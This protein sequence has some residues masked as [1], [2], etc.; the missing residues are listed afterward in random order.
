MSRFRFVFTALIGLLVSPGISPAQQ[1]F[2]F[3]GT[4]VVGP[5]KGFSLAKFDEETGVLSPPSF[6]L[7]AEAPAFF[8]LDSAGKHL[9]TVNSTAPEFQSTGEGGM[10]SYSIDPKTG[11]LTLL[12]T[13]STNGGDPSYI[14]LDHTEH[15]ALVA[16]YKGG[17]VIVYR[18][19]P[20]GSFGDQTAFDQHT[21]KGTDPTRQSKPFAHSIRVDPTN[22]FAICCDLGLDKVF[23]YK[24]DQNTGSLSP[25][26]PPFATVKAGSG[27]RH[28]CFSPD[29]KFLY[30]DSE[31]GSIVTVFAW[32]SDAGKLTVVQEISTLPPGFTGVSTDAEVLVHP[33]GKFLYVSNRVA[34]GPG[35]IGVFSI[36][37][38]SGKLTWMQD[39][40]TQGK[41][42]RNFAID[43][44]GRWL[45]VTNHD[46]N[47]GLVYRIDSDTGK[48]SAVGNPISIPYPFCE[49][50]LP[51]GNA[52]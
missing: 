28:S 19:N 23:V 35:S 21:G 33:S 50:F 7:Q 8:V 48:L 2:V 30:V 51:V 41:T 42:P 46:S 10:S 49:R 25:N 1:M 18:I 5:G 17:S 16:N 11:A 12:N 32:D 22:R 3:F 36:D 34:T 13:K 20:D 52:D 29:G 40:S 45:L 47:N 39:I 26:D 31:M 14:S 37:K 44:T 4:H 43:P 27:A 6:L 24:F 15:F 9:Y 38:D